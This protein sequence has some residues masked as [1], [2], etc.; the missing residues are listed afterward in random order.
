MCPSRHVILQR[1]PSFVCALSCRAVSVARQHVT[2][3]TVAEK[4][5]RYIEM[6]LLGL[7]VGVRPVYK[8]KKKVLRSRISCSNFGSTS[9]NPLRNFSTVGWILPA[10]IAE[11]GLWIGYFIILTTVTPAG[12]HGVEK[13]LLETEPR[14]LG[15]PA[16]NLDA[17][18]NWALTA[19]EFHCYSSEY[20]SK[21][22]LRKCGSK[23]W[24]LTKVQLKAFLSIM[25]DPAT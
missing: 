20:N 4:C 24:A 15:R 2:V 7:P 22:D 23:M 8:I 12:Q 19:P 13:N 17:I 10:A 1:P 21:M 14:L 16:R 6:W 18:L 5:M 3:P 25:M 11:E 9:V